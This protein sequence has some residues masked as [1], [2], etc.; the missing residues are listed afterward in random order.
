MTNYNLIKLSEPGFD[1][2]TE[3][4]SVVKNVLDL[5]VCGMCRKNDGTHYNRF[6]ENFDEL[7]VNE[8]VDILL[9]TDCGCEF[10]LEEE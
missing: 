7:P 6:P 1:L 8:Q 9:A 5:Y 4:L 2:R 3:H 10:S